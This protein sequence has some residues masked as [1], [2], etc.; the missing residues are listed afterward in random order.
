[1]SQQSELNEAAQYIACGNLEAFRALLEK[2]RDRVLERGNELLNALASTDI[3]HETH[4]EMV[5]LLAKIGVDLEPRR[6]LPPVRS[7][8]SL[9]NVRV[10]GALLESGASPDGWHGDLRSPLAEAIYWNNTAIIR[11][12]LNHGAAIS[13]LRTAAGTG[14]M[15]RLSEL[16][17]SKI[18]ERHVRDEAFVYACRNHRFEAA[19]FMLKNG[20]CVNAREPGDWQPKGQCATCLHLACS[21]GDRE[22]V[23]FLLQH[24]ADLAIRDDLWKATALGWAEHNEQ[25]EIARYLRSQR[26][27]L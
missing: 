2:N 3:E 24:G 19:E 27:P 7:A 5:R 22:I 13:E 9:G 25:E 11:L 18:H 15:D 8:A 6:K 26:A 21:R 12:L 10:L 14:M 17:E 1:M 4:P 20:A 16:M 23:V